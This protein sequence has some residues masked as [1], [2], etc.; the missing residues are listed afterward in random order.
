M[1]EL[2]YTDIVP[3][4]I[5][6]AKSFLASGIDENTFGISIDK[7]TAEGRF[8]SLRAAISHPGGHCTDCDL[9]IGI[10]LTSPGNDPESPDT[11]PAAFEY[12]NYSLNVSRNDCD[13]SYEAGRSYGVRQ[14]KVKAEDI[15]LNCVTKDLDEML[16]S[17]PALSFWNY[18]N[19]KADRVFCDKIRSCVSNSLKKGFSDFYN[20][21]YL[22]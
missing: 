6:I 20:Q 10:D 1:R 13:V 22:N 4:K 21:C 16:K 5:Y 7:F 3:K 17:I 11:G 2:I 19:G 14:C 8:Y 12:L 18:F 9:G 15:V